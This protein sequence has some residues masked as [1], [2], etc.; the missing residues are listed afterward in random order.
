MN[1]LSGTSGVSSPLL[2]V[3]N[4]FTVFHTEEGAVTAVQDVSFQLSLGETLCLLGE[5]GCGK[6]VTMR[7]LMRLLPP[8]AVISGSVVLDGIDVTALAQHQLKSIRGSKVSM[9]FQDPMTA[10][11]SVFTIGNQITE[12]VIAHEGVSHRAARARALEL[13]DMVKIPSAKRRLDAYPHELSGGLRQRAMIAIALSCRP[14]LLLA[15]EPTTALD[16]TVQIQILLLMRELQ[17]TLGMAIV[18][19]THDLGVA[20]EVADHV[21]VM[22]AGK[23]VE[24]TNV[25]QLI[26]TPR[27][28]YTVG[29]LN[30]TVGEFSR[31]KTLTPIGGA[32]PDLSDLP[33]G[34]AF[35]PRCGRVM[36]RCTGQA[37]RLVQVDPTQ[38]VRCH[39]VEPGYLSA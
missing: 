9:I 36:D 20:C 16:A 4:L 31:G 34:C 14:K 29:L 1:G 5:S 10:L 37:P 12:V 23:F 35:G 3:R 2:D 33:P 18:L 22:Y 6:T 17:R 13:L 21:A 32:P 8:S 28:P 26:R 11:D 24:R 38:E 19:V 30:S 27:H 15:D 7:T 39:L 25:R